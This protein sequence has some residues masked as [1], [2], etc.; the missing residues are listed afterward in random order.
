[1]Q[2]LRACDAAEVSAILAIVNSAA[3]A[4]RGVIP[5]DC[6]HEPYMREDELRRE[7]AAGVEFLGCESDAALIGVMGLQDV[8][9]VALIR[10]AYVR[11]TAQ[12]RGVGAALLAALLHRTTRRVL[13]GTWSDAGWAIR[14]YE[15]NGFLRVPREDAAE[16]LARYWDISGRQVATS[17]VLAR[18]PVV[19][20]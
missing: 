10:H 12:G 15:R 13:V 4:Y 7:I 16:L 17:V 20:A 2:H 5:P 11:P 19:S 8:A 18:P 3:E 6:F 9:D 1:M 14:F